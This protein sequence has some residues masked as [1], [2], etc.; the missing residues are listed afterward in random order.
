[1]VKIIHCLNLGFLLIFLYYNTFLHLTTIFYSLS[2]TVNYPEDSFI[3]QLETQ[4]NYQ[5]KLIH[6][7]GELW[8]LVKDK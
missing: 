8:K 2:L 5:L 3:S 7:F 4:E 1:M 6:N